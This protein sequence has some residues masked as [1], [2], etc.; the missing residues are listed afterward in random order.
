MPDTLPGMGATTTAVRAAG[1]LVLVALLAGCT[2]DD[3]I[4]T[5]TPTPTVVAGSEEPGTTPSPTPSG[6]RELTDEELLA[7][8]PEG[9]GADDLEGAI[10]TAQYWLEELGIAYSAT[11]IGHLRALSTADC[12]YCETQLGSIDAAVAEGWT[13]SGGTIDVVEGRTEASLGTDGFS[14]V[15]LTGVL[16]QVIVT[17]PEGASEVANEAGQARWAMMLADVMGRVSLEV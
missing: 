5:T 15:A 9:A 10:K 12:N 7:L 13:I 14:Y 1:A 11:R 4:V 2:G 3:G 17:D 6:G 8:M 16:E